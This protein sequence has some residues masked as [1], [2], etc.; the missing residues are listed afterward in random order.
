MASEPRRVLLVEQNRD[1]TAG[2]SYQ[3]LYDIAR[4]LDRQRFSPIVL[5][6]QTN[7]FVE[8]LNGVGVPVHFWQSSAGVRRGRL[9]NA[10]AGVRERAAFLRQHRVD[11][12]HLNNAP[13]AGADD[14]LPAAWMRGIPCITHARTVVRPGHTAV[15]RWLHR[16]YDL[17]LADSKHVAES[18]INVTGIARS[19]VRVVYEGVDADAFRESIRCPAASIRHQHGIRPDDVLVVMVGHLRPWKGQHVLVDALGRV[20]ER[21]KI[22]AIF[23]GGTPAGHA[24]YA[25]AL[26]STAA[27]LGIRA[28]VTFVGEKSDVADFMNAA[29]IVV[30]ASTEAEPFGI[31]VVEGMA[32]GK[33]V[34]ASA[35]GG[36]LEI[37]TPGTGLLFD[38]ARPEELA[39]H[40]DRVASDSALRAT[41][42][43]AA[44][45]RADVF[46][47]RALVSGTQAAYDSVR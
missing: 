27:T 34:L 30:H 21:E 47:V 35:L 19:R 32:L 39:A 7:R 14:W 26:V 25:D 42:G 37:I 6:H 31:V 16:R 15:H 40:I 43:E 11:I 17:V 28:N 10:L 4:S 5:F 33:A 23:V 1:G 3:S 41:L 46:S 29:D 22:K 24:D 9:R 45:T 44:R 2:G 12:V 18:I 38:P 20:A 8:R 13:A 36:P